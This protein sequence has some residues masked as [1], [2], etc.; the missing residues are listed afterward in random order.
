MAR[1]TAGVAPKKLPSNMSTNKAP[2]TILA[3]LEPSQD[4]NYANLNKSYLE[5]LEEMVALQNG[6]DKLG[7]SERQSLIG[8]MLENIGETSS[9]RPRAEKIE[10]V[11]AGADVQILRQD[12]AESPELTEM[13]AMLDD[14]SF[15]ENRARKNRGPQN[16]HNLYKILKGLVCSPLP[17]WLGSGLGAH[18][19]RL[20]A[21]PR[22]KSIEH[23]YQSQH[24]WH[25]SCHS[26]GFSKSYSKRL[27]LTP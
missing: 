7:Y 15:T 17:I 21:L 18:V 12:K 5:D 2:W 24:K 22:E 13:V 4:F 11:L 1:H 27:K 19:L 16:A 14:W 23:V 26:T 9:C 6:M 20:S 8:D 25:N 10:S 3:G